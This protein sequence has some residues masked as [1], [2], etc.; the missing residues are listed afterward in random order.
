[1]LS[2]KKVPR[3]LARLDKL[4]EELR[5]AEK[6]IENARNVQSDL[7]TLM[8]DL[9]YDYQVEEFMARRF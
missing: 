2:K 6:F 1:M 7:D 8:I 4:Q 9:K 3:L 5:W